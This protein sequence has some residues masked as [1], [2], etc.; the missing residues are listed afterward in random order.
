V[1]HGKKYSKNP[2]ISEHKKSLLLQEKVVEQSEAG[3]G[4]LHSSKDFERLLRIRHH[5]SHLR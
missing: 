3:C 2:K 1:R 5:I 4:D